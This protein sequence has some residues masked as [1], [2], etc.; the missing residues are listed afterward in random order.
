MRRNTEKADKCMTVLLVHEVHERV[1][2][3]AAF[4][5]SVSKPAKPRL[6]GMFVRLSRLLKPKNIFIHLL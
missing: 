2:D 1:Y 5:I 3:T 6:N 4:V